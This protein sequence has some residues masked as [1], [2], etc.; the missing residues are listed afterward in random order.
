MERAAGRPVT[1]S[2]EIGRSGDALPLAAVAA[3]EAGLLLAGFFFVT[4]LVSCALALGALFL[5]LAFRFPDLAWALTFAAVPLSV[6]RV[7]PFGAISIPSEPMVALALAGWGLRALFTGSFQVRP[8]R[9]HA[10]LAV[11][12]AIALLSVVLGSYR[13]AGLKAWVVSAA[14]VAFGFLYF[15]A[16]D[17]SGARR[18]RWI[19]LIACVGAVWGAYGAAHVLI[20]GVGARSAYG[21]ARPFFVEHGTYSAFLGMLMPV[22]LLEAMERRGTARLGFALAFLAIALGLALSF[23]RAAWIACALVLPI[24]LALWAAHRRA[25]RRLLVPVV[26]IAG[27]AAALSFVGAGQRLERHLR[28]VVDAE[29][30][31]NLERVNRWMAAWEM[32]KDRPWIGVGYGGYPD[33]YLQYR[34]K[35]LATEQSYGHFGAHSEVLRLLS[36]TGVPGLAAALWF[37]AAAGAAGLRAFRRAIDPAAGRLALALL[38]GLATYA[39][40][41]L[42]NSYLGIDKITAPFWMGLGALA[43]L[44]PV[45]EAGRL[46]GI[47]W[48]RDSRSRPSRLRVV[49]R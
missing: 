10:P 12:A 8:S 32:A 18:D 16:T 20:L 35:S 36:E 49:A 47:A 23:A 9:L 2:G 31:S 15:A 28:T 5:L 39:V 24:T 38:A 46:P 25:W 13:V 44:A 37:L 11:L 21:A 45:R 43:A 27:V 48:A 1:A 19:R 4:P 14:Y 30:V 42:F 41:A 33:A 17:C 34:H 3:G 22:P 40:H 6:E 7:L 29:N 26:L